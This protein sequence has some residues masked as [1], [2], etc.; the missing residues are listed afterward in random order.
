M[1]L[2]CGIMVV[3]PRRSDGRPRAKGFCGVGMKFRKPKW[4]SRR[5]TVNV[6]SDGHSSYD[7]VPPSYASSE[8]GFEALPEIVASFD[9]DEFNPGE[10][11]KRYH[12]RRSRG[13]RSGAPS[14]ESVVEEEY[15][16]ASGTTNKE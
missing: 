1:F 2:G 11:L 15:H 12:E 7:E 5:K 14:P 8:S 6:A 13:R 3:G 16:E 9:P 10:L 4:I